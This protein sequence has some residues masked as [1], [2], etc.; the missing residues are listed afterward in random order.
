MDEV[1]RRSGMFFYVFFKKEYD[2]V[3]QTRPHFRGP[4]EIV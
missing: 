2:Y 3:T 1:D 4:G